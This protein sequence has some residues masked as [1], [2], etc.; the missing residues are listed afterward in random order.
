[1]E[2]KADRQYWIDTMLQI[3]SPVLES[4]SRRQLKANM[5]VHGKLEDRPS[6]TYLE[7]VGR[8]LMGV[9][10]WLEGQAQDSEEER[11]RAHYASLAR[12]TIES[13]VDPDSP[14]YCNFTDGH[15]PIV[16]A[17]FLAHAILRAPNELWGK[18]DEPVQQHVVRALEQTRT[19]K[20]FFSNWLLF[21][22]M[23]ESALFKMGAAWDRMRVDFALK[24]HDQWYLGDGMY[25][26]GPEYH[27]D[28]Y[29]SYVIQPMLVDIIET[30]GD[31]EPDW[32]ALREPILRRAVRYGDIQEK[33]ISPEGAFPAYGRSIT[34]RFGAFQHL[35]QMALQHRL[36]DHIHPAQVRCAL[37]KVIRRMM[38]VPGNFD[39][40]GWLQIGFCGHQPDLGE[41]YISTGSLYLCSAVF[42]PLG[43]PEEDPFWSGEPLP[44]S[45][46]RIWTGG[47]VPIDRALV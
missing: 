12:K 14:D 7:A 46:C 21:G 5:P 16:D 42:L 27:A 35:A 29:N 20:P 40:N 28:Y 13:I 24:Q 15:Q 38:E 3:V 11:T 39:D 41:V 19:R 10:P 33:L 37:G 31:L 30:V 32:T 9:A 1:M 47:P 4:C 17:A 8:S 6:Y 23:I 43:L 44:W 34:Y 25:S 18:L 45:S 22:A 2:G 26:D 36:A